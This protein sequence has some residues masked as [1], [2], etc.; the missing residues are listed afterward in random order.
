MKRII[1]LT[2][3]FAAALALIAACTQAAPTPTEAPPSVEEATE[4]ETE[5]YPVE[6]PV[7]TTT[8]AY[9]VETEVETETEVTEVMDE[10]EELINERCSVCHSVDRVFTADK[11]AEEWE[12]N[13][14]RMIDYG[15]EVND[16]EKALMIDWLTSPDN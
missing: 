10:A 16:E 5:A 11:T 14:D 12:E 3:T 8:E 1:F 7:E 13:I 2:V 4:A 15:A 9:P 6:T